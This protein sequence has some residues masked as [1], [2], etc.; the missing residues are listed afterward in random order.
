MQQLQAVASVSKGDEKFA[1]ALGGP[2]YA[3]IREALHAEKESTG[4]PNLENLNKQ[5]PMKLESTEA[6]QDNDADNFDHHSGSAIVPG[7]TEIV[8]PNGISSNEI[9]EIEELNADTNQLTDE[10]IITDRMMKN[11]RADKKKVGLTTEAVEIVH[12]NTRV[13]VNKKKVVIRPEVEQALDTLEKAIFMFREYN[14]NQT[15]KVQSD[16]SKQNLTNIEN[17]F[18]EKHLSPE[19][20]QTTTEIGNHVGSTDVISNG[21]RNSSS[22][23]SSRY[24]F[25]YINS[26]Y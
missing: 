3:R 10:H 22:G 20:D 14:I 9:E 25:C 24:I 23:R 11:I 21:P 4:S 12:E 8:V 2:L 26:I 6:F 16:I 19:A 18:I 13:E 1:K 15:K 5:E 17:G 7:A